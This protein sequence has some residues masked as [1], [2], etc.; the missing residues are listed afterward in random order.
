MDRVSFDEGGSDGSGNR[1]GSATVLGW[2]WRRFWPR[3]KSGDGSGNGITLDF[4]D[5]DSS[6][7]GDGDEK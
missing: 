2:L 5:S 7:D 4:F 1:H 3:E 6:G